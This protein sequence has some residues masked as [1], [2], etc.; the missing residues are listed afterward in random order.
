M[1]LMLWLKLTLA[2]LYQKQALFRHNEHDFTRAGGREWK[3]VT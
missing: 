1:Q 2:Q 3:T